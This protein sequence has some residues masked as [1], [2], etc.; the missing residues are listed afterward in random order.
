MEPTTTIT[1]PTL[2]AR[3]G[4]HFAGSVVTGMAIVGGVVATL[5][6]GLTIGHCG[7]SGPALLFKYRLALTGIALVSSAV[8]TF[9]AAL[10]TRMKM[11]W[12]PWA[13][14]AACMSGYWMLAIVNTHHYQGFCLF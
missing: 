6:A 7:E 1:H 5:I 11:A 8:P 12:Q 13:I 3:I 10:A 2:S 9:W 4:F 14:V